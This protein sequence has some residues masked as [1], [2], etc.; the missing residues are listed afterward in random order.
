ML[1]NERQLRPVFHITGGNGWI[2]DPNGLVKFNGE[3]HVFY[4]YYSEATYWGPMHWGHVKS[5]DLTHWER[6]PVAIHPDEQD[7]GCFSGSAIAHD[8]KLW[9]LYTSYKKN[10]GGVS[11]RQ[12]QALASSDDGVHFF[13]H[14]IVIGEE[15]LPEGYCPW[16]FR[17]PKLL[18]ING[19]FYCL[20]AAKMREGKGR[21]LLYKSSDLFK[22]TFVCDVTNK[23]SGGKMIECPDYCTQLKL[24]TYSEQF[25]PHEGSAHLNIHS[26]FAHFGT[27]D[28]DKPFAPDSKR[29]IADYGFDFYASQTFADEPQ[30]IPW[31]SFSMCFLWKSS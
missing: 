7:D 19:K 30:P 5:K 27:F 18:K 10:D 21:I 15:D 23:D 29:Q 3:Y 25:Q 12:L 14:G 9:L 4:Q 17:D 20:V 16:S 6:L 24:L 11:E 13:K 31:K 1:E 26:S 22:W 8:G 28:F 2:N